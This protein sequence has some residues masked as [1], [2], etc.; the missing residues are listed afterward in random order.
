MANTT[1]RVACSYERCHLYRAHHEHPET[2]RGVQYIEV[3]GDHP[4]PYYCSLTCAMLD[5]YIDM[6]NHKLPKTE[7]EN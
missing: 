7:D 1:K 3:P 4:G 6:L 2:P 5:G